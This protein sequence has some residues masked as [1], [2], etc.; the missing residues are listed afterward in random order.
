[1]NDTG[2]TQ[3][4]AARRS[5]K[6]NRMRWLRRALGAALLAAIATVLVLAWLPDPVP[7]E[8][9]TVQKGALEV[10][11]EEDGRTRVI[12]RFVVSAPVTGNL[13]RIEL[14]PGDSVAQGQVLARIVPLGAPL[15]DP[16][17][18][19]TAQAQVS[20]AAA[21]QRQARAQIERAR[22]AAD[23]ARKQHERSLALFQRGSLSQ[24]ELDRSDLEM[25]TREAELASAEF[26]LKVAEHEVRM[27][28]AALGHASGKPAADQ[29]VITVR[30]PIDGVVLKVEQESEGA[31]QPGAPLLELGDP[32]RLEV[33]VDL[34]TSDAVD[35]K[36]GARARVERWGGPVLAARVRR[37]EPSAFTRLSALGVEEQRVNTLLELESPRE[38]W[39]A[40]G[41]GY[42]VE[43]AIVTWEGKDV[44]SVPASAVF[45]HGD[46]WALFAVEDERATLRA[47]EIGHRTGSRAQVLDGV[48]P[49]ERV[50]AHPR[51]RVVEGVR[52]TAR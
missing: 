42:R 44:V 3:G 13:A 48:R 12:D 10:T 16:R 49:G 25:R 31:V 52:V 4:Q 11:V 33:V 43:V 7:V 34:L 38:Q 19:A 23:Y 27:A 9:A 26:A 40:L 35:V 36:P 21:A 32:A 28:Q 20:V 41:D 6:K 18:R 46:G 5:A 2:Q 29:D 17:S 24:A 30:S 39:R 14:D 22:A 51:D 8:V 37:I 45:R 15:L 1:M 50:I 47:V